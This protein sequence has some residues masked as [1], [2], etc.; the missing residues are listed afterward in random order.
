MEKFVRSL[1][2]NPWYRLVCGNRGQKIFFIWWM[3]IE[4]LSATGHWMKNFALRSG[5]RCQWKR[6]WAIRRGYFPMEKRGWM[7]GKGDRPQ[8][9]RGFGYYGTAAIPRSGKERQ[10]R[11]PAEWSLAICRR[12]V[13]KP[14][15]W[16]FRGPLVCPKRRDHW[17][18][19]LT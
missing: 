7:S 13:E 18:I 19:C 3:A 1:E 4:K 2:N 5:D 16:I 17:L 14:L 12:V 11:P 6:K 9:G 10:P 8:M 15:P